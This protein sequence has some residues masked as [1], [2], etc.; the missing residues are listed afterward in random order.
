[1]NWIL[2]TVGAVLLICIAVGIYKGAIKIA[3]SLAATI[4]T[5]VLVFFLTPYASKAISSLT[6]LDDMI[7]SQVV[8]TIGNVATAEAGKQVA[9]NFLTEDGVRRVLAA[10]GITEEQ[11]NAVGITVEDIANGNISSE[12]L[13]QYGISSSLLD[14]LNISGEQ[15]GE[16]LEQLEI[17]RDMQIAAIEGADI[18]EIFKSL[19]LTNNNDEIYKKLGAKTFV[20]YVAS[21]L[22]G[23]IINVLAF[24]LTFIIVT[25]ILRAIIFALDIVANLPVLGLLNR[26]AGGVLGALGGLIIVWFLFLI[27]TMLYTTSVGRDMYALI[28]GND[29]L[30]MIYEYNPVV[31]LA[32][33][34]R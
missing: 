4:L 18:P 30:K 11:L 25:I 8:S 1:M 17:P 27:V 5:F 7:E 21:F 14:G 10:A 28:Q 6:P 26:L 31:K 22:S 29:F 23:L 19:L 2:A 9:E 33:T 32:T 20:E 3:V 16:G 12:E 13:A 24:L 15:V 34:L